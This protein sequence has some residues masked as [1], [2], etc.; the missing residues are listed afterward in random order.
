[1]SDLY[2]RELLELIKRLLR[3]ILAVWRVDLTQSTGTLPPTQLPPAGGSGGSGTRGGVVLSDDDPADVTSGAAAP[4]ASDMA[5]RSDHVHHTAGVT[6]PAATGA[7][8]L[9]MCLDGATWSRVQAVTTTADGWL[10]NG[11]GEL[12]VIEV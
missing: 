10:V 7:G 6:I 1:M 5:S 11:A 8:Q 9:L 4:G 2:H 12:L 3:E